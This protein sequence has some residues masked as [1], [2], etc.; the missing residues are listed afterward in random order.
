MDSTNHKVLFG[1][2]IHVDYA[3]P[4]EDQIDIHD[5]ARGL[6]ATPRF[7]GQLLRPYNVAEHSIRVARA[8]APK[9]RGRQLC[10]LMHDAAEAYL[11]DMPS[12]VKAL[13]P[14]YCELE[15]RFM[16][17]ISKK[18]EFTYPIPDEVKQLDMEI[19]LAEIRDLHPTGQISEGCLGKLA[20]CEAHDLMI[21]RSSGPYHQSICQ[22]EFLTYYYQLTLDTSVVIPSLGEF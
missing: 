9:A 10:A 8:I 21:T 1:S 18:Y 11:G 19:L 15:D 7:R 13:L 3:N 5:I 17:V 22:R 2:G 20:E 12:P 16:K 4:T 6:A 14:D